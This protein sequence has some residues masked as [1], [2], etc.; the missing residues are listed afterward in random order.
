MTTS[1]STILEARGLTKEFKGFTAV[2]DVN[3]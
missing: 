1:P 3:L 2:N